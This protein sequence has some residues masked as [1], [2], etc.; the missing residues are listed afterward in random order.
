MK[1]VVPKILREARITK[2]A[3]KSDESYGL[4]GAF[5]F[6]VGS[7]L[8]TQIPNHWKKVQCIS[9]DG[10]GQKGESKTGW[11]HVSVTIIT[12]NDETTTPNWF[13]MSKV[14]ERFWKKKETVV[15]YHPAKTDYVDR[16]SDTLHLWRPIEE[17]LGETLPTPPT[18]LV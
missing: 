3:M 18:E 7:R 4:T 14:K 10:T 2:G 11:E 8:S 15:Q 13:V 9:D 1:D 16:H 5:V 17:I 12:H 6:T